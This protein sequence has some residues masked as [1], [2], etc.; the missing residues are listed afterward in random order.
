MDRSSFYS[1]KPG[2]GEQAEKLKK[3]LKQI[4]YPQNIRSKDLGEGKASVYIQIL[5]YFFRTYS[6]TITDFFITQVNQVQ[7]GFETLE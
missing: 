1:S 7:G 3:L 4:K 5:E 2:L 6:K